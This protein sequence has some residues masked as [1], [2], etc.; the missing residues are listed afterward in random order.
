[1]YRN[2][3]VPVA[4]IEDQ[5]FRFSGGEVSEGCFLYIYP[6]LLPRGYRLSWIF[7]QHSRHWED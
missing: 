7:Y 6:V 4:K 1:M 5:V 3:N 2:L